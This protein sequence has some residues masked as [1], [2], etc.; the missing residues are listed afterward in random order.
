MND[1]Y[2]VFRDNT[3]L[4]EGGGL[5]ENILTEGKLYILG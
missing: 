5:N 1:K 3:Y 2:D 4:R